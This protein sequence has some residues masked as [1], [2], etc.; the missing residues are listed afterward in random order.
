MLPAFAVSV[1]LGFLPM[2]VFSI[3]IYRL[4]RYEKE[5]VKLLVFVF[6]WGAI[7]SA[8]G[9]FIINTLFGAGVYLLSGSEV[10]ANV[11][12]T[13][14]IAPI[15]EEVLKGFAVLIVFLFFRTEFDSIL[16]GII[17]GAVTALGFAATENAQ[18]IFNLGYLVN[19][20]EGLAQLAFVRIILVGWQ[21]P[22]YTAFTGIGL[23]I[24]RMSR[25][26]FT[27]IFT[28]LLGLSV[29]I[30]VHSVHNTIVPLFIHEDTLGSLIFATQFDWLGWSLMLLFIFLMNRHEKSILRNYLKQEMEA[31][32]I[33]KV[34]YHTSFSPRLR[35]IE[36]NKAK[37]QN[38]E[39]FLQVKKFYQLCAELAHKK[40]QYSK[41]GS[42]NNNPA[43][44]L[45]TRKALYTLSS[46]I[47][48]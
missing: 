42:E 20:W 2:I 45:A 44:I 12:V 25:N 23:A 24:S 5:P 14:I 6:L 3:I 4:D 22:F 28:P 29:A 17:Y 8:G 26:D 1:I 48:V 47:P 36:K 35:K 11:S 16:D 40:H 10:A 43:I 32:I 19:S 18:Y 38:H 46:K 39:T 27:K 41:L 9:A 33:T 37:A 21:H 7:V 34:Q 13:S 30:F 15:S 31:G